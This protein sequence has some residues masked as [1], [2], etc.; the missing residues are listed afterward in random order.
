MWCAGPN[1]G[2]LGVRSVESV[3]SVVSVHV[4]TVRYVSRSGKGNTFV[5]RVRAV[6]RAPEPCLMNTQRV[7]RVAA[8]AM[9]STH[10]SACCD[11]HAASRTA[12]ETLG[13]SRGQLGSRCGSKLQSRLCA[14]KSFGARFV[15]SWFKFQD[16]VF[17]IPGNPVQDSALDLVRGLG[18]RRFGFVPGRP[19]GKGSCL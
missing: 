10:R 9:T 3:G 1:F 11:G 12:M 4:G 17:L 6:P 2:A 5:P 16:G 14:P 15:T 8:A 19:G 13:G 7:G 18:P